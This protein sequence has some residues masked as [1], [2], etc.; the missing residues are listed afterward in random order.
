MKKKLIAGNWKMNGS[1]AANEALVRAL[2]AGM[3]DAACTVA[4][5]VPAPYLAQVQALRAGSRAGT[6]RAGRVRS[7]RRAPSPARCR[8][9]CS[10]S[11]A[12]A[13]R[14]SATPSAA[15]TTA[16][17][18]RWWR[19]RPR[20]RWRHGITPDRLRRRDAGRARSR[21]DG[22]S[23]QAPDG[24]RDPHQRPLHQRDRGGLR[25]RLGHRHRQDRHARAG[26]AGARRA[27]RAAQGG[28]RSMRTASTSSTAAA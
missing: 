26:A 2:V 8:P 1:L 28:D 5:C 18:T 12:C 14:S 17:P 27:A 20:P 11:S 15:S 25:A 13:T 24:R 10:R 9:P 6:R 16:R 3:G 22:G 4:V 23:R 7:M 21:P 19:T